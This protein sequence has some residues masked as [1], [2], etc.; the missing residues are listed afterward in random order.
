MH[1]FST[2][3]NVAGPYDDLSRRL[4]EV[5]RPRPVRMS[6][7]G[8][9]SAVLVFAILFASMGIFVA[10][11]SAKTAAT[12][13]NSGP[14]QFLMYAL[15]IVFVLV[16]GPVMLR[17]ITRQKPLLAEGEIGTGR[18]TEQRLARHG[19]TIRY[20]FTTP[21]GEHFSRGA[22]DGSHQL[23]VGMNVPIFY[24]PQKPKKQLALCAS[25]YEVVLPDDNDTFGAL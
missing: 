1:D 23:S 6:R 9:S 13:R 15:P 14:A 18:V 21:L 3:E 11:L 24:D 12:P 7:R 16:T 17:T 8:K 4:A 5:A 19:P 20:E 22:A 2:T 25:F 10:G